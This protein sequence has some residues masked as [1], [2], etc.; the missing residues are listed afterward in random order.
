MLVLPLQGLAAALGPSMAV[1]R[2]AVHA[3]VAD[4]DCHS[5][6]TPDTPNTA[7]HDCKHCSACALG[8]AMPVPAAETTPVISNAQRLPHASLAAF[9]AYFPDGPERPPRPSHI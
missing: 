7:S 6:T 1:E 8:A 5:A 4:H 3:V 2:H 9:P